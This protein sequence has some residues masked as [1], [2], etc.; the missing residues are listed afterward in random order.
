MGFGVMLS[1]IIIHIIALPYADM[2]LLAA[3]ASL[4]I[5][6]NLI[7]SIYLFDEKWVWKFDC[8]AMALI[9]GGCCSIVLLSNK[10]QIEYDG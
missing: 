2:T 6:A 4:A 7:L 8:T 5:I 10:E 9:I 1:G 3:N